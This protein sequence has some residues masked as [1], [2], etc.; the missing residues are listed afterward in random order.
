MQYFHKAIYMLLFVSNHLYNT[1]YIIIFHECHKSYKVLY[2]YT[3]HNSHKDYNAYNLWTSLQ[4][5]HS[6]QLG[7]AWYIEQ[8]QRQL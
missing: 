8:S 3:A 2:N 5:K 1:F 7:K 4:P 6:E